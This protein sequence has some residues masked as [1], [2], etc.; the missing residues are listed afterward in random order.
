MSRQITPDVVIASDIQAL[1]DANDNRVT[2][3][4]Q[5]GQPEITLRAPTLE[6]VG[7]RVIPHIGKRG[8]GSEETMADMLFR[9]L[10]AQVGCIQACL[11]GLPDSHAMRLVQVTNETGHPL[12]D[13]CWKLCGLPPRDEGGDTDEDDSG[14]DEEA[15]PPVRP[16]M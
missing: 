13:E 10:A 16:S 1:M 8:K 9:G 14:D 4:A 15:R 7:K 6:E 11:P 5:C 2:I 3:P 12:F